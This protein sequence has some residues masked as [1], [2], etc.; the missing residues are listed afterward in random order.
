MAGGPSTGEA[1]AVE[2]EAVEGAEDGGGNL[3]GAE[4]FLG[5]R[6]DVFAGDGFDGGKNF[7][8]GEEAAE[9]KFLTREIGHAGAGGFEGEHEGTLE[10]VLGT[11]EFFVGDGRFLECAKFR[12]GE[13]EDLADGFFCAARIDGEHAGVGI[14]SDFAEDSVGEAALFANVLEEAGKNAAAGKSIWKRG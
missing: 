13:I 9:I 7:V 12:E 2:G 4:K 3:F 14:R 10:M 5:E 11:Q 8:E 1:I 6:L